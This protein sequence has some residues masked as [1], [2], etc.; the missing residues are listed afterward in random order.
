MPAML[1]PPRR[2]G[3]IRRSTGVFLSLFLAFGPTLSAA[4]YYVNDDTGDDGRTAAEATNPATPWR[5]ITRALDESDTPL[6]SGDILNVAAGTYDQALGEDFPLSLRSGVQIL[7]EDRDT[8]F[9]NPPEG[10]P[11]FVNFDEDLLDTTAL[12]GFTLTSVEDFFGPPLMLF[13]LGSATMSPTISGNAFDGDGAPVTGIFVL[14]GSQGGTFTGDITGNQ[15]TGFSEFNNE[16]P[17]AL[18]AGITLLIEPDD[19]FAEKTEGFHAEDDLI[20][21]TISNNTFSG[22]AVGIK[23][24]EGYSYSYYEY[25]EVSDT[26]GTMT[27]LI[28]TNTFEVNGL[29]VWFAYSGIS[30]TNFS[31]TVSNNTSSGSLVGVLATG[32]YFYDYNYEASRKTTTRSVSRQN[33]QAPTGGM[34]VSFPWLRTGTSLSSTQGR[35]FDLRERLEN[36]L[37]ERRARKAAAAPRERTKAGV[38]ASDR[39]YGP[40]ITGNTITDAEIGG[41]L[42]LYQYFAEGDSLTLDVDVSENE[43][44]GASGGIITLIGIDDQD[45]EVPHTISIRDNQLT[46]G[47][48]GESFIDIGILLQIFSDTVEAVS[49]KTSALAAA[50]N[51]SISGNLITGYDGPG[52]LI[53]TEGYTTQPVVISCNTITGNAGP[54][55]VVYE[56][57]DPNPDF[58]GGGLS[59]GNNNIFGNG[60]AENG[61]GFDFINEDDDP[62]S[63]QNNFWGSTDPTTIDERIFDDDE[64]A[65][66]GAV[67]FSN[68]LAAEADCD[69]TGNVDLAVMISASPD[70]VEEG[71]ELTFTITVTNNGPLDAT[72]V[73][74]ENFLPTDAVVSAAGC[75]VGNA[76]ITCPIGALG[77][78]LSAV[79]TIVITAPEGEFVSDSSSVDGNEADPDPSNN[80]AVRN[81]IITGSA[82]PLAADLALTKTASPAE[83]QPQGEVTYTL[84][85][86]N[87]GPGEATGVVITDTLPAGVT[88]VS[89][90]QCTHANGVVT[91][92][93]GT[94]ANG[95][96]AVRTVVVRAPSTPGSFVNSASASGNE[97]DPTPANNSSAGAASVLEAEVVAIPTVGEWGLIILT[98]LLMTTALLTMRRRD[99]WS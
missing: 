32:Y 54:G 90:S 49:A 76:Q 98:L 59:E 21:P 77:S 73:V 84:T 93:V 67:D 18:S 83:V 99:D 64:S 29:D 66:S 71:E 12:S 5:T 86:T 46:S 68:F 89:S 70:P 25:G 42:S 48:G 75:T 16:G 2:W 79:R 3:F 61:S 22:N 24:Y 43:I 97:T 74:L 95:A 85:V 20:S 15:F 80:V 53:G 92:N 82:A 87:N 13:E 40:T 88:F 91:C 19:E 55:V 14:G 78:G 35:A 37:K 45:V 94:L 81:V 10:S 69:A 57:S 23:A 65:E 52:L 51:V 33:R 96:N 27:P 56:Q 4:T 6:V 41:V 44:S 39:T 47:S 1:Q 62:V 36:R 26:Y 58:G 7:G 63:A 28:D 11:A 30:V 17:S 60:I 38:L 9:I 8:T 50:H 31:P 34:M 72:G